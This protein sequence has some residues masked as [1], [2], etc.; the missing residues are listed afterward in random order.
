MLA[1]KVVTCAAAGEDFSSFGFYFIR[2]RVIRSDLCNVFIP[3]MT[4][5]NGW[6]YT[7]HSPTPTKEFCLNLP[8]S[9]SCSAKCASCERVNP[10]AR[11]CRLFLRQM[12]FTAETHT[13]LRAWVEQPLTQLHSVTGTRQKSIKG[14][15][16]EPGSAEG[17]C[18][19]WGGN[20]T[21]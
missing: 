13:V 10:L 17:A 11:W 18:G 15:W 12:W 16:M 8:V 19:D 6:A 5:P 1:L 3:V 9:E 2:T 21:Q 14:R 20:V 7:F 4:N